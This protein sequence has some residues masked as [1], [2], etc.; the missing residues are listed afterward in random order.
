MLISDLIK[1]LQELEQ[2]YGDNIEVFDSTYNYDVR[3][4]LIDT[5]NTSFPPS[6]QMPEQFIVV[7]DD[8]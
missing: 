2:K 5:K 7:G 6:W 1:K 3:V 8:D 4:R